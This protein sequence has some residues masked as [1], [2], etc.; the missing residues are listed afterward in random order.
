V[1][2]KIVPELKGFIS[3]GSSGEAHMGNNYPDEW[4]IITHHLR[5]AVDRTNVG[6]LSTKA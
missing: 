3:A 1:P 5:K 2:S 4:G 6:A